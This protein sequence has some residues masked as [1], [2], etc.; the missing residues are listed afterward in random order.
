ML[1]SAR[2]CLRLVPRRGGTHF[3]SPGVPARQASAIAAEEAEAAAVAPRRLLLLGYIWPEPT[4]SAA[5]L[6]DVN[7]VTA[8]QR[9]G[10]EVHYSTPSKENAFS[11]A[12][13]ARGVLCSV[14]PPNDTSFDVWV[15]ALR[16]DVVIFDR[17]VT[18]ERFGH[19][20]AAHSP[21]SVRVLDTQ[22]LH[23]LRQ[24]RQKAVAELDIYTASGGISGGSA[25]SLAGVF[26]G[27]GVSLVCDAALREVAA[28]LRCD[29]TLL[30]SDFERGLLEGP[31]F[32]VPPELL[33]VSR[34]QY[35]R[36]GGSTAPAPAPASVPVP[37]PA[38]ITAPITAPAPVPA[39][40]PDTTG[41]GV[42]G[43][44]FAERRH[45]VMIGNFRH[46]PNMD[47]VLWMQ[48]EIWPQ[49][50]ALVSGG[51]GGGGEDAQLH[52]YG[53]YP[54]REAM[55]LSS[56]ADGFLVKGP[57]KDHLRMLGKYRVNLAP[58]RFGAGIKGKISDGWWSG[59]PCVATPVGAEGMT[60]GL[61]FGGAVSG[62][63]AGL[64]AAAAALY[65]DPGQWEAAQGRGCVLMD[66]LY[67]ED[68][69][70][71]DL[72]RRIEQTAADLG[73]VRA[74]NFYGAMLCHHMHRSDKYFS[75]WIEA[76][77]AN[78]QP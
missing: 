40:A 22:D 14:R 66:A 6:R 44:S 48:R 10:W 21:G 39:P 62:S 51:G 72:L 61:P 50:R 49:L 68:A 20:V 33:H 35:R 26:D 1:I 74:R 19:R 7:L 53:A 17:F 9:A 18:E 60:G 73:G 71:E 29:L 58:L 3:F 24:Q 75:Q 27:S 43:L 76:K 28:A 69:L 56:A 67:Q 78:K 32:S 12:L 30:I 59:T 64:A 63:A 77:N 34:L 65:L 16:P 8:F 42:A 38:P 55:A 25:P 46:A 4:S 11:Q 31:P 57:V 52:I 2:S 37:A 23:F 15:G 5:G 45:F 47:A 70:S 54:P 13:Q 41:T 36:R